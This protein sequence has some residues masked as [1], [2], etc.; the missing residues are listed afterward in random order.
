MQRYRA[1]E[2]PAMDIQTAKCATR[3]DLSSACSICLICATDVVVLLYRPAAMDLRKPTFAQQ[4]SVKLN[5]VL[6]V[7]FCISYYGSCW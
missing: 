6:Y 4:T 3:R 5:Q 2:I 1:K 7:P